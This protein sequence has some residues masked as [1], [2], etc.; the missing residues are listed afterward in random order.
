MDLVAAS[1]NAVVSSAQLSISHDVTRTCISSQ[2]S[3]A[4]RIATCN[5]D[6]L[7]SIAITVSGFQLTNGVF[8]TISVTNIDLYVM[9][10]TLCCVVDR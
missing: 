7:W 9:A 1:R 2:I 4:D 5:I 3:A 8:F 10:W 6:P